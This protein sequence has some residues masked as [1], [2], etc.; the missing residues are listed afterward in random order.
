MRNFNDYLN[1]KRSEFGDKFDTS[2]LD[3]RFI[4]AW[5]S[6]ARIKVRMGDGHY[7]GTVGIT[8]GWRPVF[9]LMHSSRCTGSSFTLRDT[10]TLVAT[11]QGRR[12]V[13]GR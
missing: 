1:R 6:G 4:D 2:E 12:Y 13:E 5:E 9:L 3:S 7:F 11:K 8:T 10:S